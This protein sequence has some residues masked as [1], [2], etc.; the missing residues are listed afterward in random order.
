MYRVLWLL[1]LLTF[2]TSLLS[3]DSVVLQQI[4]YEGNKKTKPKVIQRELLFQPG[5][6]LSLLEIEQLFS[7]TRLQILSTGLF[8]DVILNLSDYRT[9][10]GTTDITITV[11][12]NWYLFPVPIFELADRNFSVWWNEQDKSL[13]RTNYGVRINHFNTTGN[14][15]ALKLVAHLGYTRKLELQYGYP[16][17]KWNNKLGI[18]GNIIYSDT[19]EIAY[20]TENNKSLFY[21]DED[22]RN[23]L[24]RFRVGPELKYRPSVYSFHSLRIEYHHNKIDEIIATDLNPDYFQDGR[25]D[26]RFFFIEYDY[27]YD[28]RTYPSYPL[29][30]Y[31]I[32]GNIKKE[33]L[34]IFDGFNN[35]SISF[36]FEKHFSLKEKFILS[37]RNKAKANITRGDVAFAN[38]TGIGWGSDIV[39]GYELYVMDGTDYYIS[40]NSVKWLLY[41]NNKSTASWLPEQFRKMNISIFLRANFDFAYVNEP[42]YIE[43]NFLNNRWIYGYGPAV[44]LILFNNFQ[45]SFEYSINDIGEKGLYFSNRVNF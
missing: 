45:Y 28:K 43:T 16:Y 21:K 12:E 17:W 6:T 13:A 29:G 34:G 44:D 38:N 20:K 11:E 27:S 37:S 41:D 9:A 5:D 3:Q 7:D 40:G 36:G 26:L 22:E 32:F 35:L 15:D 33:G 1:L 18:A 4:Q 8:N 2:S 25:T 10:E 30:G 31:L 19:K 14:R 23:M 39:G 24:S 42:L